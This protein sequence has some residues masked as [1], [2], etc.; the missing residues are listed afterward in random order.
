ML[1]FF[2]TMLVEY[3]VSGKWVS[4]SVDIEHEPLIETLHRRCPGWSLACCV[5]RYGVGHAG[6]RDVEATMATSIPEGSSLPFQ[7]VCGSNDPW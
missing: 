2:M 6:F 4:A 1:I 7:G 5:V 3:I